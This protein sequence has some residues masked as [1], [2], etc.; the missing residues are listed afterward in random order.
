[1]SGANES[2]FRDAG[3]R[4]GQPKHQIDANGFKRAILPAEAR[5]S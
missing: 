1:M 4:L 5:K 3:I 2:L